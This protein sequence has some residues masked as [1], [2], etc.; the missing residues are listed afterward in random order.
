MRGK[1]LLIATVLF[2]V[3]AGLVYWSNRQK[4]KE[5]SAPPK[6][7]APDV[8][9]VPQSDI[10]KI[11]LKKKDG[12]DVVLERSGGNWSIT[13][14]QSWPADQDTVNALVSSVARM[15]SD[16]VVEQKTSDP[17]QYGLAA[18]TETVVIG[19]KDGK[20]KTLLLG[21]DAPTGGEVYAMAAG[22]PKVYTVGSFNRSSIDKSADDLR[23]KRLLTFNQD[24][25]ARVELSSKGQDMEFGKNNQG[26]WQILKPGPYRADG[27]QVDELVRKLK[28]AKMDLTAS[29]DDR[30][31]AASAFA[32]AAPLAAAKVTD[33]SGT[34]ELQVRKTSSG[35]YY[36]KSSAVEGVWKTTSE[37]AEGLNKSVDGFRNKKLFDFGFDDP[38]RIDMHDGAKSYSFVRSG[39]KWFAN[40]KEL[41]PIGIESFIDKLR[42]LSASKFVDSGFAAPALD[43]SVTS[44]DNKRAEKALFSKQ[45]GDYIAKRE[46]E[47][48]LYQ[49]DGKSVQDV[50][51]AAAAVKP[52]SAAKK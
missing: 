25:L 5:D 48:S 6:S 40:G 31:K 33:A 8:I 30:K 3:L 21:D 2:A 43:I 29:E 47:A 13:S 41:D 52:A 27:L 28:D 10:A 32:S 20:S 36:A 34:Q 15:T 49:V 11:E 23:D 7:T 17:G 42:E 1:G 19:L 18:P 37:L 35:D 16:S 38:N 39:E 14:P 46:N 45:D 51:S 4:A 9:S 26:D 24:S 50:E 12:Q 44:K 22:D